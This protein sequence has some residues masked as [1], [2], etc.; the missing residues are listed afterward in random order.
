MIG[1]IAVLFTELLH[2]GRGGGEKLSM[3]PGAIK[4]INSRLV[5]Y[6]ESGWECVK[7]IR[8]KI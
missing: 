7:K 4:R 8:R 2:S 3:L 1:V 5:H 6:S